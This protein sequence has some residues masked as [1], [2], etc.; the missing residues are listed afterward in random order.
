MSF[1]P[2]G[3]NKKAGVAVPERTRNSR[4]MIGITVTDERKR[5]PTKPSYN[6]AVGRVITSNEE[7]LAPDSTPQRPKL[8][9]EVGRNG[10]NV[11][12]LD[13]PSDIPTHK[14][15]ASFMQHNDFSRYGSKTKYPPGTIL[16]LKG[17]N[18]SVWTKDLTKLNAEEKAKYE[19][20]DRRFFVF[21]SVSSLEP[22]VLKT[23]NLQI[24][25]NGS[26]FSKPLLDR[27]PPDTFHPWENITQESHKDKPVSTK[28]KKYNEYDGRAMLIV[29]EFDMVVSLNRGRDDQEELDILSKDLPP[30]A[31]E[32][33]EI[34]S[35]TYPSQER[36]NESSGCFA[37]PADRTI[38]GAADKFQL[39]FEQTDKEDE[40]KK[41][42]TRVFKRTMNVLQWTGGPFA[43]P[44]SDTTYAQ[45]NL[46][47][48]D[49]ALEA[50]NI[51]NHKSWTTLGPKLVTYANYTAP[52]NVNLSETANLPMQAELQSRS[53]Q[54]ALETAGRT[55]D[56]EATVVTFLVDLAHEL[57]RLG[58]P[59][60]PDDAKRHLDWTVDSSGTLKASV[61]PT[62]P[63]TVDHSTLPKFGSPVVNLSEFRGDPRPFFPEDPADAQYVFVALTNHKMNAA[64]LEAVVKAFTREERAALMD[65]TTTAKLRIAAR[66]NTTPDE[67]GK[68]VDQALERQGLTAE[69]SP[70]YAT[71]KAILTTKDFEGKENKLHFNIFAIAHPLL[72][73]GL[74]LTSGFQ[75]ICGAMT[76]NPQE[77]L[78]EFH[79]RFDWEAKRI[80]GDHIP[81]TPEHKKLR[82]KSDIA[83]VDFLDKRYG[84]GL[85]SHKRTR[86]DDEE[87]DDENDSTKNEEPPTK[88]AKQEESGDSMDEDEVEEVDEIDFED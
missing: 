76:E 69:T 54:D 85:A 56:V 86:P 53:W 30:D 70:N 37:L 64:R 4:V 28:G 36:R 38:K 9:F 62:D 31:P 80:F 87:E 51:T 12:G 20:R 66:R 74:T 7:D 18:A 35:R 57:I 82:H 14:T 42:P 52:C 23:D 34:N 84:K 45:V 79:R 17:I 32:I 19:G 65:Y 41:I 60:R 21:N 72:R 2:F 83:L 29:N 50:F 78:R 6:L 43:S 24:V 33:V 49:G 63:P 13:I 77:A 1:N 88:R 26:N 40:T 75:E 58:V 10:K 15:I 59:V 48:Y 73:D 44:G 22:I 71:V 11:R 68:I 46:M 8:H 5:N 47:A 61:D 25:A 27:A 16:V 3:V 67:L 39:I 55:M 81:L